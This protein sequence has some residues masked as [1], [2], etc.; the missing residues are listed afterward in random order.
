[1]K[2]DPGNVTPSRG[3]GCVYKTNPNHHK[4]FQVELPGLKQQD[5]NT[6]G[7]SSS[8]PPPSPG[9]ARPASAG[10]SAEPGAWFAF[11]LWAPQWRV[12]PS[13]RFPVPAGAFSVLAPCRE[14]LT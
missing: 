14:E 8:G 2:G 6:S 7:H 9:E 5:K 12:S 4:S 1:M 11:A 3:T 13:F 10:P